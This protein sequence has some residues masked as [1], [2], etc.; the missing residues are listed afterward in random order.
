MEIRTTKEIIEENFKGLDEL[1][2]DK[3]LVH[4]YKGVIA[5]C[6]KGYAEQFIDLASEKAEVEVNYQYNYSSA[7]EM[8]SYEVDKDSILKLK[9][10]LI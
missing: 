10:Q 8:A 6:M 4:F 5:E 2:A 3:D 9:E 7:C 1:I